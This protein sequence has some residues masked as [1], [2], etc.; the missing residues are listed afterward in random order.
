MVRH[1]TGSTDRQYWLWVTRREY[2]SEA[3][4]SDRADLDP[5]EQSDSDGWWTCHR[6]TRQGDLILLYRT[7]PRMD[8]GYLIQAESDA[9]ALASTAYEFRPEWEYACGYRVLYKFEHPLTLQDIRRDPYMAEWGALRA[10]F[11]RRVYAIPSAM[12]ERLLRHIE[13]GEPAFA[14]FLK[15]GAL[16]TA[17][18]KILLEEELEDRL[19]ADISV[20]RP[21]GFDLDVRERQLVCVGHGGRIDLL[22]Y[23]HRRKCYVVVELKN[24]MAGQNT[25]GQIS[26]YLGWVQQ[27]FPEG[28]RANGLVIA[29][30]F[31]TRFVAAAATNPLVGY[32]DLKDL[33]FE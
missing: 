27:R 7:S 26:T 3:D 29:R 20:L 6:N 13:Q 5:N 25:F 9:Y 11:Q 28:R 1:S 4:G 21:F 23:D 12:W 15:R 33:G 19:A 17:S 22:C 24:V 8:F 16:R 14:R 10:N 18:A 31:D 2:Y 30:G 32:I